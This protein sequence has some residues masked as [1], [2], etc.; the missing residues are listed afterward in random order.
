MITIVPISHVAKES[1]KNV[2]KA[3]RELKPDYVAVELCKERMS[4]PVKHGRPKITKNSLLAGLLAFIQEKYAKEAGNKAGAEMRAAMNEAKKVD[5]KILAIDRPISITLRRMRKAMGIKDT[6]RLLWTSVVGGDVP[7]DLNSVPD[8][9]MV[10][11]LVEELKLEFP[12]LYKVL[13]TERDAWM[14]R[15]LED[16]DNV[17]VVIGAGHVKGLVKRLEHVSIFKAGNK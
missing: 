15:E 16:K 6:L 13:I 4:V 11:T 14:A 8:S 12:K 9:A 10:E 2:R 7:F 3:I 5:A 17:V 1:V